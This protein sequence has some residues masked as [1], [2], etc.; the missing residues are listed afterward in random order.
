MKTLF[1]MQDFGSLSSAVVGFA[2]CWLC[3]GE[4][5]NEVNAQNFD[6][7]CSPYCPFFE[8]VATAELSDPLPITCPCGT[9]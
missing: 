2:V 1:I 5:H 8:P 4:F 7:I 3:L 6:V 9:N